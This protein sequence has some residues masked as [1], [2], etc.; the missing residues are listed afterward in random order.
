ML[1]E[2]NKPGINVNDCSCLQTYTYV[3][4]LQGSTMMLDSPEESMCDDDVVDA[5]VE[6]DK[7]RKTEANYICF[8]E[9][10]ADIYKYLRE[11][12]VMFEDC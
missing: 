2:T 12:E 1:T 3:T 10:K 5:A 8:A 11:K 6:S 7:K 4:C 9:Y